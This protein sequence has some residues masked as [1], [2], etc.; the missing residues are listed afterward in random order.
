[1]TT[2]T[3][4]EKSNTEEVT[5]MEMSKEDGTDFTPPTLEDIEDDAIYDIRL[6]VQDLLHDCEDAKIR[7]VM[8]N[9]LRF[10]EETYEQ[11]QIP[12]V[13]QFSAEYP[14]G[15]ELPNFARHSHVLFAL[16]SC[17]TDVYFPEDSRFC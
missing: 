17:M 5:E 9:L 15:V 10:A 12:T 1:M 13:K 16:R 4:I 14:D 6:A 3:E 7:V 11:A 2:V 8:L